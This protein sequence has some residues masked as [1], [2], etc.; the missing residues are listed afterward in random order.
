MICPFLRD[1][2]LLLTSFDDVGC[3]AKETYRG[4]NNIQHSSTGS[5]LPA[6]HHSPK[7]QRALGRRFT[8]DGE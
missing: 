3:S 2:P 8:N 6:P 4:V 1:T 7:D 5:T